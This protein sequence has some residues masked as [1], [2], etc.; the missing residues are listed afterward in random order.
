MTEPRTEMQ[1]DDEREKR[2]GPFVDVPAQQSG[3]EHRMPEAADREQLADALQHREHHRLHER[4]N[5]GRFARG[6][7]FP[8][9]AEGARVS[10]AGSHPRLSDAP[11]LVAYT[12]GDEFPKAQ[13]VTYDIGL[14]GLTMLSDAELPPG[15]Q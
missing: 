2:L 7:G 6:G 4:H 10:E 1:H 8:A 15:Q 11:M 3:Y 9:R 5:A 14:G 12:I 13:T